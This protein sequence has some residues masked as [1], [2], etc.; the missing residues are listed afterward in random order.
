MVIEKSYNV[1]YSKGIVISHEI[2]PL[3][4]PRLMHFSQTLLI[5]HRFK[6]VKNTKYEQRLVE[7]RVKVIKKTGGNVR[8]ILESC[9]IWCLVKF[10][11][12]IFRK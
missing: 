11:Y 1:K 12:G 5:S 8:V 3:H 4:F 2:L 10:C 9:M 7:N 6:N